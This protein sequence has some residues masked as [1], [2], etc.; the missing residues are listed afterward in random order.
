M[1]VIGY[2]RVSTNRQEIGP[3]VQRASIEARYGK[4]V[5]WF[6]DIGVSGSKTLDNRPALSR[7][8]LGLKKGDV[9]VCYRLDRVARDLMTQLV[10]E[11]QV[12]RAGATFISCQ[13]EGTDGEGPEA[14]LFRQ[15]LGAMAEFERE[16]IKARVRASMT[17]KRERGEKLG[18][19]TPFGFDSHDGKLVQN[20]D[21][22]IVIDQVLR[23]R[24]SGLSIRNIIKTLNESG[25]PTKLGKRWNIRQIQLII[26]RHGIS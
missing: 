17:L 9:F 18:G 19:R 6:E 24:E 21:E 16:L 12:R 7:A 2:I 22:R 15:I 10:V 5:V 23:Y 13:G 11:D 14:R 26:Q 3:E 20:R 1:K 25:I 4:D 8:I